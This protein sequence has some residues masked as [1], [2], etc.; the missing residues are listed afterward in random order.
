[1]SKT[2]RPKIEVVNAIAEF[3]RYGVNFEH[4]GDRELKMLC[5]VHDDTEPSIAFNVEKNLWL[6]HACKAKGD[7]VSF[8]AYTVSKTRSVIL[9]DLS[10]RYD[11]EDVKSINPQRIE[12]WHADIESAGPLLKALYDRGITA[13]MIRD[14]RIGYDVKNT[15]ITIPIFDDQGRVVNVRKYLPGAP[16]PE[17]MRNV[18]GFSKPRLYPANQFD[19]DVIW[20]LGGEMKALLAASILNPHNIGAI[21]PTAGEGAWDP[22]WNV[23]FRG[24]KVFLCFDIDNAGLS[25]AKKIGTTLFSYA[26]E[27]HTIHIPLDKDE[28][29]TGDLNDYVGGENATKEDVLAL[30]AKATVFEP[31]Y[32]DGATHTADNEEIPVSLGKS[33]LPEYIG[34]RI[35]T[36]GIVIAADDSPYFAPSQVRVSCD[37]KQKACIA[38]AIYGL[39]PT[40]EGFVD[41]SIDDTNRGLLYFPNIPEAKV[42]ESTRLCIGVPQCKSVAFRPLTKIAIR[43]IRIQ[44]Q[45]E[46]SKHETDHTVKPAFLIGEELELN[47]PYHFGAVLWTSPKT[48]QAVLMIT[49]AE[50][51]EDSLDSFHPESEQLDELKIFQPKNWTLEGLEEKLN[52][53]YE[54]FEANVTRIYKRRELHLTFDLAYHSA[55][56]FTYK[57]RQYPG[58]VN[59][60]VLGDSAQGKSETAIRLAGHYSLGERTEC[61]NASVAGLLGG[62]QQM[63]TR[64]FVSWGVIPRQDR[65]LVV[66]E[67]VKGTPVETIG[68]LTDMRSSGIAE[69]DKIERR[70]CS[71]RTRLVFVSNP[72]S[73][74]PLSSYAYGI[75]AV[76]EL[77]GSPEDVRRFDLACV[78]D[79]RDITQQAIQDS[80]KATSKE[81]YTQELCR[82]LV[83]Y[84]WTRAPEELIFEDDTIVQKVANEVVSKF[85]S[86]IPLVD[87]A[88][89][90]LKVGRLAVALALRTYSVV[91]DV[92]LVRNVHVQYIGQFMTEMYSGQHFGYDK[93]AHH[94]SIVMQIRDPK[95][96]EKTIRMSR[97][98][99]D[100]VEFLLSTPE[101]IDSDFEEFAGDRDSGRQLLSLLVRKGAIRRKGT[102]RTYVKNSG[103]IDL[104]KHL[105]TLNLTP[106]TEAVESEI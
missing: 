38:C 70:R 96:I 26:T 24:K 17:K 49:R 47:A 28:Y 53:I 21:T 37:R 59:A 57:K 50:R 60:L 39:E 8:L 54:D 3:E 9:A 68:K 22:D 105:L 94:E 91:D 13:K 93:F 45:L 6:C 36:S 65:R 69:L 83:L 73:D 34:K 7:V 102:R 63:G 79:A 55:L 88:S 67:E 72:R 44:P 19:Y 80:E 64:W 29:P 56:F 4:N 87:Q 74:L 95:I 103:F 42:H 48:Q 40:P 78:L 101:L 25:A 76:P 10:T 52:S 61:K 33:D 86:T 46:I 2:K 12:E 90:H 1:M 89:V 99:L 31:Q 20:V 16:G 81:V 66:L 43:E 35:A 84:A 71:A 23:K 41:V 92:V 14:H 75:E 32:I 51:A 100:L 30:Q 18:H 104:L 5:P 77:I 15:R 98:P 82:R 97:Y 58:W 62:L 27:L 85:G 11:M 106:A